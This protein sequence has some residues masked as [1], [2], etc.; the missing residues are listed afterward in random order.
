[1]TMKPSATTSNRKPKGFNWDSLRLFSEDESID[2]DV[3]WHLALGI[4]N[5]QDRIILYIGAHIIEFQKRGR[6]FYEDIQNIANKLQV[7]KNNIRV[8]ICRSKY[9]RKEGRNWVMPVTPWMEKAMKETTSKE[10]KTSTVCPYTPDLFAFTDEPESVSET[11]SVCNLGI[12]ARNESITA[13]NELVASPTPPLRNYLNQLLKRKDKEGREDISIPIKIEEDET[14]HGRKIVTSLH[15]Q[16]NEPGIAL[17][18]ELDRELSPKHHNLTKKNPVI[19]K[20]TYRKFSKKEDPLSPMGF[21]YAFR[22]K[23]VEVMGEETHQWFNQINVGYESNTASA[24]LDL[25]AK[26]GCKTKENVHEWI[27]WFIERKLSR[28]K[29]KNVF[30][31]RL[32]AMQDSWDEYQKIMSRGPVV[33]SGQNI[34][35]NPDVSVGQALYSSLKRNVKANPE[36]MEIQTFRSL[37]KTYGIVLVGLFL[38]KRG[39]AQTKIISLLR[40]VLM[41]TQQEKIPGGLMKIYRSSKALTPHSITGF[42]GEWTQLFAKE[43]SSSAMEDAKNAS[44]LRSDDADAFL[45]AMK[46]DSNV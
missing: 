17:M 37:C 25:L 36:E 13:R 39:L 23:V 16:R 20:T 24:L 11:V 19:M 6:H 2:T 31:F 42:L 34:S 12:T 14:G 44:G 41:S 38:E 1:M 15:K 46:A 8:A 9:I 4:P 28:R 33:S 18:A 43:F 21:V 22:N 5:K 30:C 29:T 26:V 7:T 35:S 3:I 32:K 10:A 27:R 40:S 45:L